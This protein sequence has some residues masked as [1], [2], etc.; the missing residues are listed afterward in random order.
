MTWHGCYENNLGGINESVDNSINNK[1][2]EGKHYNVNKFQRISSGNI[3]V[4]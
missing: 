2:T 4:A 1:L 3:L